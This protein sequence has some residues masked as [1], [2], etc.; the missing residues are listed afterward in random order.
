MNFQPWTRDNERTIFR[1]CCKDLSSR[2]ALQNLYNFEYP[3]N[4][5][6]I[7]PEIPDDI[8]SANNANNAISPLGHSAQNIL[9][10]FLQLFHH[11]NS[12]WY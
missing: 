4:F 10:K 6:H 5:I 12:C 2:N 7:S 1:V 3:Q 8:S 11:F 9:L